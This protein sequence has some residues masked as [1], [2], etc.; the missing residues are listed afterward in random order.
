MDDNKVAVLIE[1]LMSRFRVF[2][3]GL[4]GLRDDLNNFKEENRQE[5]QQM[6]ARMDRFHGENHQEHQQLKQMVQDLA[7][8]QKEIKEKVNSLDQEF[9]IKLRRVK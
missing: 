9:E 1:D 8:D 7:I 4:Q 2:G 3:E 5:H 6:M